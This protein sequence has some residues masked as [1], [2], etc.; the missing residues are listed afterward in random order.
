M[1]DAETR[2]CP[3]CKAV[4]V[5]QAPQTQTIVEKRVEVIERVVLVNPKNGATSL[6]CPRCNAPLFEGTANQLIL[7][8]CG[9]CGGVWLDNNASRA[10]IES[11]NQA[12]LGLTDRAARAAK[13]KPDL[14]KPAKCPLDGEELEHVT[15]KGVEIDVCAAHGTWFDA[16]EVRRLAVAFNVSRIEEEERLAAAAAGASYDYSAD[17]KVALENQQLLVHL[18]GLGSRR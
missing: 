13:T 18:L 10:V 12:L 7:N 9:K 11:I 5:R 8:G 4:I 2:T 15:V 17:A 3:F 14:S 1:K 16:G 6:P